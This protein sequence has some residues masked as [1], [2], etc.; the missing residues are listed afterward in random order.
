MCSARRPSCAAP[1][2]L[3]RQQRGGERLGVVVARV[4]GAFEREPPVARRAAI[5]G[6]RERVEE[7][8]KASSGRRGMPPPAAACD[9]AIGLSASGAERTPSRQPADRARAR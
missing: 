7:R 9:A 8:S 6:P 4:G 5:V 3:D 2:A 1:A